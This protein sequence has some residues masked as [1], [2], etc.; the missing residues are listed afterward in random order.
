MTLPAQ[1]IFGLD[2]GQLSLFSANPW[3]DESMDTPAHGEQ[4]HVYPSPRLARGQTSLR[5]TQSMV[6]ETNGQSSP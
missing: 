2:E 5:E 1:P 6:V 4:A 3:P